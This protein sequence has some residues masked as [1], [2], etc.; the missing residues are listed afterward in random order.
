MAGKGSAKKRSKVATRRKKM[1]VETGE[2]E[3]EVPLV[4]YENSDDDDNDTSDSSSDESGVDGPKAKKS[5]KDEAGTQVRR[6]ERRV[7]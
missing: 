1:E 7:I 4:R 2:E 3:P 5:K 6:Q